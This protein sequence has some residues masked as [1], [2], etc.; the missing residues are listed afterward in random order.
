MRESKKCEYTLHECVWDAHH[1][2]SFQAWRVESPG[3][4]GDI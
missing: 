2:A 3:V 1:Q 4:H